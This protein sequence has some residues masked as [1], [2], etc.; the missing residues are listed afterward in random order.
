MH[1]EAKQKGLMEEPVVGLSRVLRLTRG[2]SACKSSRN[3]N[4]CMY[5]RIC[6][7]DAFVKHRCPCGNKKAQRV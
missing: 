4:I 7:E 1:C 6:K 3:N 5:S 2:Y